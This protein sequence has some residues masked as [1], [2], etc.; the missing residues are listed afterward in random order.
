MSTP[1]DQAVWLTPELV[2]QGVTVRCYDGKGGG[3]GE[4]VTGPRASAHGPIDPAKYIGGGEFDVLLKQSGYVPNDAY[5][6]GGQW[7]PP[8]L[9]HLECARLAGVEVPDV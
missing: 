5:G 6:T 1:D 4:P 8:L 7:K 9:M 3:C 2:E